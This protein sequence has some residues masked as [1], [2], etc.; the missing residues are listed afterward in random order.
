MWRGDAN[1]Q[2]GEQGFTLIELVVVI[3]ILS[4]I[5]LTTTQFIVDSSHRAISTP[6]I[7]SG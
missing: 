4:I 6:V 3:V 5:A 7:G 2:P 1:K